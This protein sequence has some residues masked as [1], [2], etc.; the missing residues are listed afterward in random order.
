MVLKFWRKREDKGLVGDF[1]WRWRQWRGEKN[2]FRVGGVVDE[3]HKDLRNAILLLVHELELHTLL[4]LD[5]AQQGR[6][7]E[8]E[9]VVPV[10]ELR[11]G[12]ELLANLLER[13]FHREGLMDGLRKLP[14]E[15]W[16]KAHNGQRMKGLN[17]EES[18][19]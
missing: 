4:V 18:R 7:N 3:L 16:A 9:E 19:K 2:R 15:F 12:L 13:H 8:A 17:L 10:V 1:K 14:L 5:N 11:G 6:M